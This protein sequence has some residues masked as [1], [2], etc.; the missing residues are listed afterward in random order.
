[1]GKG[2]NDYKFTLVIQVQGND[3]KEAER[4]IRTRIEAMLK[5]PD[6]LA[7]WGDLEIV[8]LAKSK[9]ENLK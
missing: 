8:E 9:K 2:I 7:N 3:E 6:G 1:M 4:R 5:H